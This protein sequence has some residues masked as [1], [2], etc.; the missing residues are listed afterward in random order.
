MAFSKDVL[1]IDRAR[2][3]ERIVEGIRE[4]VLARL[5]RRGASGGRSGGYASIVVAALSVRALGKERVLGLFMHEEDS[6][7]ETRSLSAL[8]ARH[9]GV[10]TVDE[11]LTPMLAAVGCYRRRDEAI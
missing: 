3:T 6:S 10:S 1:R 4:G 8:I 5:K 2:E 9:L 11:D 7:S